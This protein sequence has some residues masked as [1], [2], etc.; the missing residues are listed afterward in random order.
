MP[1]EE[2]IILTCRNQTKS[3]DA[4]ASGGWRMEINRAVTVVT[5]RRRREIEE[6]Y[7][8]DCEA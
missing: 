6:I 1:R 2:Y 7:L 8:E 4:Q 3:T 5:E